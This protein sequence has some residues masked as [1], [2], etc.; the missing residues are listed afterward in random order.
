MK[1]EV[2]SFAPR[3]AEA[4]KSCIYSSLVHA[5]TSILIFNSPTLITKKWEV[6][7][8]AKC[9]E[10]KSCIYYIL[11]HATMHFDSHNKSYSILK[12]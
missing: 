9:R 12:F 1:L 4:D 2:V 3:R 8:F 7:S 11:V 10:D 6:V 5:T